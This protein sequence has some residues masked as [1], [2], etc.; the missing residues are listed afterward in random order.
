[1]TSLNYAA[2]WSQGIKNYR[3]TNIVGPHICSA[4]AG[5]YVFDKLH[6][7]KLKIFGCN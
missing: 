4:I 6:L 2:D 1:M 5:T 7:R 3:V